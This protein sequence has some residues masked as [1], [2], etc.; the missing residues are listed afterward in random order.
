MASGLGSPRST[1]AAFNPTPRN[2]NS[3]AAD[4]GGGRRRGALCAVGQVAR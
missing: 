1:I 2:A 3:P 4:L